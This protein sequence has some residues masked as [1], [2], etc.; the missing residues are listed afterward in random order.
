MVL[1]SF[2]HRNICIFTSLRCI[3]LHSTDPVAPNSISFESIESTSVTVTWN[4]FVGHDV[5]NFEV[6]YRQTD[7]IND[8]TLAGEVDGVTESLALNGLDP[9][10]LYDVRIFSKVTS[11]ELTSRSE[12]A[13]NS[14]TTGRS[15]PV[16][17][18]VINCQILVAINLLNLNKL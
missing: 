10:A 12:A 4:R 5:D 15:L 16:V 3:L 2:L 6:W 1:P 18:Y 13:M 8:Y 9:S 17:C 11:G 7:S 14:F